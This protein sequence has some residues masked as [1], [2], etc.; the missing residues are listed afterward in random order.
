MLRQTTKNLVVLDKNNPKDQYAD[1]LTNSA[2]L[3][4]RS[5]D[6]V[7]EVPKDSIRRCTDAS[8]KSILSKKVL[9]S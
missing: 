7:V 6:K 1:F 9:P 2:L 4:F 5:L 3:D 8:C